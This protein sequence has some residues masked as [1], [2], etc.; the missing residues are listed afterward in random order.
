MSEADVRSGPAPG[1]W[2]TNSDSVP[3][4]LR[5]LRR[6]RAGEPIPVLGVDGERRDVFDRLHRPRPLL[7]VAGI[8]HPAGADVRTGDVLVSIGDAL[9][10]LGTALAEV[11]SCSHVVVPHADHPV[12]ASTVAGLDGEACLTLLGTSSSFTTST[13]I[14][15]HRLCGASGDVPW[16]SWGILTG[17]NDRELSWTVAK[18]L[19]FPWRR[20]PAHSVVLIDTIFTGVPGRD[21]GGDS[22]PYRIDLSGLERSHVG[23]LG[24]TAHGR[25]DSISLTDAT[26]CGATKAKRFGPSDWRLPACADQGVCYRKEAPADSLLRVGSLTTDV[27]VLNT[28][29]SIR[30][31]EG[32]FTDEALLAHG[33]AEGTSVA[34]IGFPTFVNGSRNVVETV[35]ETV[36]TGRRLGEAARAANRELAEHGLDDPFLTLIGPPW[37]TM[38]TPLPDGECSEPQASGPQSPAA[39][40]PATFARIERRLA[41]TGRS[42][43]LLDDLH[44]AGFRFPRQSN[45]MAAVRAQG[46]NVVANLGGTVRAGRAKS[47]EHR[48]DTLD[49]LIAGVE[50]ELADSLFERGTRSW[51]ALDQLWGSALV[52]RSDPTWR[53]TCANCGEETLRQVARHPLIRRIERELLSCARCGP[54]LDRRIGGRVAAVAVEAPERWQRGQDV[55]VEITVSVTDLP[56]ASAGD[57]VATLSVF[58]DNSDVLG[59]TCGRP[60]RQEVGISGQSVFEFTERVGPVGQS[61]QHFLRACVVYGGDLALATRPFWIR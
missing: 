49:S 38:G 5:G 2:L 3:A 21:A 4:W 56:D 33:L 44:L 23:L 57:A 39:D 32:L 9:G 58:A 27:V 14:R 22:G 42:V 20:D 16:R 50:R 29:M 28:C 12:L 10:P 17:R 7:P 61:H 26:L 37:L 41:W 51:R 13:I 43:E 11:L 55:R 46:T 52:P 53:G 48:I 6:W 19:A 47:I 30:L 54:V 31:T 60:R 59:V 15:T 8:A 34:L 45:M 35:V 36:A 1:R 40:L 18:A 25:E 24:I